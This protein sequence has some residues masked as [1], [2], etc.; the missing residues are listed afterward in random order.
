R[1]SSQPVILRSSSRSTDTSITSGSLH[2]GYTQQTTIVSILSW[3]ITGP[4][5]AGSS[6][7]AGSRFDLECAVQKLFAERD[8]FEFGQLGVRLDVAVE[9]QTDFPGSREDLRVLDGR[10]VLQVIRCHRGVALHH[11][12][13][14]AV[15]IARPVE[16]RMFD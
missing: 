5:S 10:L 7:P 15:E 16:P 2:H 12:Q 6:S 14:I 9:R 8:A 3:D 4:A 13:R 11:V 1:Q